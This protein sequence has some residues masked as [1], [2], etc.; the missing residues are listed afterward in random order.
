MF[1]QMDEGEE[2]ADDTSP[3]LAGTMLYAV[4][5]PYLT[6]DQARGI[7]RRYAGAWMVKEDM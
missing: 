2:M 4:T 6:E 5:I 3:C 1:L 7:L